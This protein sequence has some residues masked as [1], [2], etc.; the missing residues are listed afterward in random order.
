M[1]WLQSEIPRRIIIDDLVIRCLETTD[2]NQ[3]V[4]A[5]TESLPELLQWMPWAKFEPQSVEQREAFILQW[6]KDWDEKNDFSVGVF[7]GDL[8]VGC[9]GLH[10]RHSEGQLEIG[11]WVRSSCVGQGIATRTSQALTDVAFAL[12]E[13]Q[14]VLIAHDIANVRSQSIPKR[15]GFSLDKEYDTE[16]NANSATGRNRLWSKRREAWRAD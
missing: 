5:V 4:D 8:L 12:P 7:R 15:L 11:Y 14:E 16:I 10:L 2:A 9:A 1:T 6:N 3:I 13:V